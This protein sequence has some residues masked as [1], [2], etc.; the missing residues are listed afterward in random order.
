MEAR[1][2]PGFPGYAATAD[3][4]ILS[5]RSGRPMA[6]KPDAYGYPSLTLRVSGRAIC[7]CVHRLVALAW[8]GAPPSPL[9]EVAHNDGVKANTSPRNLRWATRAENHADMRRHG[10][11]PLG[12]RHGNAR[13]SDDEVSRIRMARREGRKRSAIAAEFGVS[14]FTVAKIDTGKRRQMELR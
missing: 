4:R 1:P 13:L 9:H 12:E 5:K 7:K 10:T 2:I 6:P 3:G 8:L 11:L 14:Y